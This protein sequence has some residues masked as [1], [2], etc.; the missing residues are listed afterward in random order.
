MR[1][2][3]MW[4]WCGNYMLSAVT[5]AVEHNLA[6][7]KAKSEYIKEPLLHDLEDHEPTEDEIQKKREEFVMRMRTM[8]ANWDL[9]HPKKS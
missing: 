9:T 6:G 1:D 8:K 3:E 4:M 5:V 7:K 2:E